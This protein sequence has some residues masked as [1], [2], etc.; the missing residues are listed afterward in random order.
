MKHKKIYEHKSLRIESVDDLFHTLHHY[1]THSLIAALV[2]SVR[3]LLFLLDEEK[4]SHVPDQDLKDLFMKLKFNKFELN[5]ID[6]Q[7]IIRLINYFVNNAL[8][9]YEENKKNIDQAISNRI[10][11]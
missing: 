7:I 4:L 10:I 11:H 2:E 8:D 9:R 3:A 6:Q 1:P 5:E